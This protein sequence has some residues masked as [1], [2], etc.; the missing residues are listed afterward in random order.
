MLLCWKWYTK[1]TSKSLYYKEL[2]YKEI[3]A[4]ETEAKASSESCQILGKLN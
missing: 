4:L 1:S 3:G 2:V